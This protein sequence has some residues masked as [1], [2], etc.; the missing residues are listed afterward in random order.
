MNIVVAEKIKGAYRELIATT[1][2]KNK[3]KKTVS[4]PTVAEIDIN[5]LSGDLYNNGWKDTVFQ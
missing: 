4:T 2:N 5:L 1:M 3:S